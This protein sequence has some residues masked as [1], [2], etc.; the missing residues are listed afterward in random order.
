MQFDAVDIDGNDNVFLR[1]HPD[2]ARRFAAKAAR[3][4]RFTAPSTQP[5]PTKPCSAPSSVTIALAPAL[6][7]VALAVRTTVTAQ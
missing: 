7:D 2:E 6:A 3:A 1:L 4:A 5:P